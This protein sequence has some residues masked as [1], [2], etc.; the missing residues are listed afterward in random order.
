MNLVE[1][2]SSSR[3]V[4]FPRS[5]RR[6][7]D[8]FAESSATWMMNWTSKSFEPGWK[9]PYLVPYTT[10][11]P[12]LSECIVKPH[13]FHLM[14]WHHPTVSATI[15]YHFNV[16]VWVSSLKSLPQV[17]FVPPSTTETMCP[18]A[19]AFNSSSCGCC[20]GNSDASCDVSFRTT[21]NGIQKL[22][23]STG[24]AWRGWVFQYR[25]YPREW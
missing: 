13:F 17:L 11:S 8:L 25:I 3:R 4:L 22:L 2:S 9:K 21:T 10:N 23:G 16:D 18:A 12:I 5:D 20:D 15:S 14:I 24:A 6:C 19:Q 1:K 7:L